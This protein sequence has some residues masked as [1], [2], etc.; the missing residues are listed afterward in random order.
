MLYFSAIHFE[1]LCW[2]YR[3]FTPTLSGCKSII[4]YWRQMTSFGLCCVPW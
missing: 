3:E 4:S 2:S 1:F